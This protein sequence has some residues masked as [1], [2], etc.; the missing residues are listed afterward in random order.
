MVAS[1]V[2]LV[3]GLPSSGKTSLCRA[4]EKAISNEDSGAGNGSLRVSVVNESLLLPGTRNDWF[5]APAEEKRL[6][7]A[8]RSD[9]ERRCC[10]RAHLVIVDG[11]N[12]VKGFRYELYCIAK[13]AG[14]RYC[15]VHCDVQPRT[16]L[17]WNEERDERYSE[18]VMADLCARFERPD[19]KFR[20]ESPLFTLSEGDLR[21]ICEGDRDDCDNDNDGDGRGGGHPISEEEGGLHDTPQQ[22]EL[23]SI[24]DTI[25]GRAS[26]TK[27]L[28]PG[29]ATSSMLHG[30][31]GERQLDQQKKQIRSR[32]VG[33]NFNGAQK[34][35]GKATANGAEPRSGATDTEST[36]SASVSSA[37]AQNGQQQGRSSTNLLHDVDRA[38]QRIINAVTDQQHRGAASGGGQTVIE[39]DG[40][41]RLIL[42]RHVPVSELKTHKRTFMSICSAKIKSSGPVRDPMFA[43]VEYL[44]VNIN[45]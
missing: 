7:D 28:V 5:G 22:V 3:C 40:G 15:V 2:V 25:M 6:R 32:V 27:Q 31:I 36:V 1:S 10:E 45:Q 42:K 33:F 41:A 11:Q 24:V 13:A 23:R 16:C 44:N 18:D 19:S 37:S 9:F 8:V 35:A 20:W 38:T 21:K 43:F 26:N 17:E 29:S 39:I 34:R 14:V 30:N 4:L 12:S